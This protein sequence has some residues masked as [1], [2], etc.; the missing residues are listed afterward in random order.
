ME[1]EASLKAVSGKCKKHGSGCVFNTL[2]H[3]GESPGDD[4]FQSGSPALF[5]KDPGEHVGRFSKLLVIFGDRCWLYFRV[6]CAIF[7][8]TTF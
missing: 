1:P 5:W 4:F 6:I 8:G 3:V 7:L 2:G